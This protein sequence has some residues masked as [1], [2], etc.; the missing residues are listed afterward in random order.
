ME[1]VLLALHET[2]VVLCIKTWCAILA[3]EPEAQRHIRCTDKH[4]ETFFFSLSRVG[5]TR[6]NEEQCLLSNVAITQF[7]SP[8][9]QHLL[10]R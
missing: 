1:L 6:S 8:A 2:P 3:I 7:L 10:F 4:C 9:F 5:M